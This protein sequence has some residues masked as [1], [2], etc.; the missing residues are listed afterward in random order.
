MVFVSSFDARSVWHCEDLDNVAE[1]SGQW[2]LPSLVNHSFTP[3]LSWNIV[4]SN[5]VIRTTRDVEMGEELTFAYLLPNTLKERIDYCEWKGMSPELDSSLLKNRS[6]IDEEIED[7]EEMKND[8]RN[9]LEKALKKL[10]KLKK[11][12]S[13]AFDKDFIGAQIARLEAD[14]NQCL[15]NVGARLTAMDKAY[16]AE[17]TTFTAPQTVAKTLRLT[18]EMA[19]I[20]AWMSTTTESRQKMM[21]NQYGISDLASPPLLE[22]S[23]ELT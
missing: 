5:Y 6:K 1:L 4:G 17:S 15:G 21:R 13:E 10:T 7:V 8:A 19:Q 20:R 2:L 16:E 23:D 9:V 12:H 11:K 3:N 22:S 18:R 14:L